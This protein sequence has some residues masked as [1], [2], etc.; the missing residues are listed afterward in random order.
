MLASAFGS[1]HCKQCGQIPRSEFSPADRQKM[2]I[3]S[4][5]LVVGA[6]ALLVAV[7]VVIILI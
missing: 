1:F 2:L 3:G 5:L 4:L 7:I 6:I